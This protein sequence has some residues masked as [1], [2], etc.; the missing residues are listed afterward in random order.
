M[1]GFGGGGGADMG[2][3][4]EHATNLG[5]ESKK[6]AKNQFRAGMK[7]LNQ[8]QNRYNPA[9][10]QEFFT[11]TL[12]RYGNYD[13]AANQRET[14]A[15]EAYFKPFQVEM[16]NQM[17]DFYGGL[18]Q[19]GRNNSRGQFAQAALAQNLA[20]NYGR[21]LYDI[22]N[23]ARQ[24]VLSENQALFNPAFSVLNQIAGI[25]QG[26]AN[27]RSQLADRIANINSGSASNISGLASTQAQMQNQQAAQQQSGIGSLIGGG[28]SLAGSLFSDER[29]KENIQ[30]VGTLDN[31]LN[32]Y[33][34]NYLGS[35]VPQI[36]LIAQ[37]VEKV[38]PK[39]VKA[40]ESGYLAV[41]YKEAVK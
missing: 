31:G 35:D 19:A 26:R 3:A 16:Q 37:E 11:N 32:V 27:Y 2:W 6:L 33:V 13:Q 41:N 29:L 17:R 22:G 18:G 4:I 30:K 23:Q 21:Q 15:R 36:G 1:G 40:T 20:D 39:A 9:Q 28:I 5:E 38:R 34:F 7:D 24:S 12:N 25:D 8:S 10:T 14:Q